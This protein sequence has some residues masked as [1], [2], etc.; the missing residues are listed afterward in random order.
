MICEKEDNYDY[1][2]LIQRPLVITTRIHDIGHFPFHTIDLSPIQRPFLQYFGIHIPNVFK[3]SYKDF[4]EVYSRH[5]E[6][7]KGE[8]TRFYTTNYR[9]LCYFTYRYIHHPFLPFCHTNHTND[10]NDT[11]DT[12][13]T[14]QIYFDQYE[15]LIMTFPFGIILKFNSVICVFLSSINKIAILSQN[16]DERKEFY[17]DKD[18]HH[19][20]FTHFINLTMTGRYS[21]PNTTDYFMT[22]F[23][24]HQTQF[25]HFSNF[26]NHKTKL[27]IITSATY[28][29]R[30]KKTMIKKNDLYV[31]T[32]ED[33]K[34]DKKHVISNCMING[35]EGLRFRG[36]YRVLSDLS[37]H[38]ILYKTL[39]KDDE[40]VYI[41]K[42]NE[43]LL[44]QL[45]ND[46]KKKRYRNN[47]LETW[48]E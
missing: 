33:Y 9:D 11:N 21:T 20:L 5:E 28:K 7:I 16:R 12:N 44:N 47:W 23:D 1:P 48:R 43:V 13:H 26:F 15:N 25:N 10:T 34:R 3:P 6:R 36:S 31:Y 40:Y 39:Q 22:N 41:K 14:K 27:S 29:N 19:Q 8:F 45:T 46:L 37:D 38:K 2:H 42:N 32:K 18:N 35:D 24:Q 17:H 30:V 4:G